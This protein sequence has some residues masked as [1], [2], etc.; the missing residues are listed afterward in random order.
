MAWRYTY[1]R[2]NGVR[3]KVKVHRK[4]S[5]TEIVRVVKKRNYSDRTRV[6]RRRR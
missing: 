6:H 1:R 2:I 4:Q 3:K 5:G